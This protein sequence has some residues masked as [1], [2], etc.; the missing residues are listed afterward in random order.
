MLPHAPFIFDSSGSIKPL[1]EIQRLKSEDHPKA[2]IEQVKYANTIIK[3][4]VLH[5]KQKNKKN[6]ILIIAGD[7]GFRNA[8]GNGY[9]IFDN[10]T[11]VYLPDQN[12]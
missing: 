9:M 11:A 4:L 10:L 8:S 2:F 1:T 3:D 6:T 7:H 12:Y 5:I